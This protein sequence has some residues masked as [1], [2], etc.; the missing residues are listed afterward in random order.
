MIIILINSKKSE[1]T[2]FIDRKL[3]IIKNDIK[4]TRILIRAIYN[5]I[6]WLL[7]RNKSIICY[8]IF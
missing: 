2:R 4:K 3:I 8:Y 6:S 1:K 7:R 5:K